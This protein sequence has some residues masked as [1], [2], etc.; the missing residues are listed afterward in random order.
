MNKLDKTHN[1]NVV[2]YL[3][4]NIWHHIISLFANC[5]THVYV[6]ISFSDREDLDVEGLTQLEYLEEKDKEIGNTLQNLL[7]KVKF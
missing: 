1:S 6:Y 5:R 7:R 4:H 3:Q 2:S